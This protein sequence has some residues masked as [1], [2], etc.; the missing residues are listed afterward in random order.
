MIYERPIF[1]DTTLR[2]GEQASGV[3]FTLDEKLSLVEMLYKAG[4]REFEVGTPAMGCTAIEEI[5][6]ITS[7][8]TDMGLDA[9]MIAWCRAMP[10]EIELAHKCGVDGIHLSFPVSDKLLGVMGKSRE[11][12]LRELREITRLAYN[13]FE[14][15]SVGAQDAS[16]AD[17]DFLKEFAGE[18]IKNRAKRVRL[19]D[20][21][22]LLNPLSTQELVRPIRDLDPSISIEFHAHNDLGMACANTIS[23]WMA[24]ADALSTTINGLGERAGNAAMEEVSMAIEKSL[25]T[26]THLDKRMFPEICS[27]VEKISGRK[28]SVSKPIVGEL[29]LTHESGIHTKYLKRDRSTYQ[30][31][32][33]EEIGLKERRFRIGKHTCMSTLKNALEELGVTCREE[34]LPHLLDEVRTWCTLNKRDLEPAELL[35]IYN[36]I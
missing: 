28:N 22:G 25:G 31:F 35:T 24:G 18:A 2:D 15:V 4:V 11:W 7:L 5:E 14:F 6:A 21:V 27:Y 12:V 3:A 33:A 29:V 20:T 1:V 19:A 10:T 32:S 17:S 26:A 36:T 23:A 16:R 34:I 13:S 9:R 30:L 8:K